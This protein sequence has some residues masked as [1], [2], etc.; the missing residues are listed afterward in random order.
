MPGQPLDEFATHFDRSSLESRQREAEE[1]RQVFLGRFPRESLHQLSLRD[2]VGPDG[3]LD[4][5][6]N[7]TP[8][9]GD[10][11]S[12]RSS[13]EGLLSLK[14]S[15]LDQ[16]EV[17]SWQKAEA[18]W[19]PLRDT[20]ARAQDLAAEGR[21]EEAGRRNNEANTVPVIKRN[22]L[23]HLYFAG[24][25]LPIYRSSAINRLL[26][27][28]S[29]PLREGNWSPLRNRDLLRHLQSLP[30][31]QGW[32]TWEL[33][34]LLNEW[35]RTLQPVADDEVILKIAPGE[36]A[37]RWE[38]C[39][40]GGHACIGWGDI[41]DL[42]KLDTAEALKQAMDACYA[43]TPDSSGKKASRS[44]AAKL[45]WMVRE[46]KEGRRI[47]ANRG[48]DEILAVG[49]VV[50][51]GYLWDDRLGEFGHT[52]RVEWDT[53]FACTMPKNQN[54]WRRTITILTPEQ[55]K[56]IFEGAPES[57]P[58]SNQSTMES[59]NRILHGPPGTGKT[60]RI[61]R[62]AAGIVS[63]GMPH[64]GDAR[65]AY[66]DAV[67]Q[68]RVRLVTFHQ[69][70][71]YEDFIEGIRP[72]M[73]EESASAR[74]QVRDGVFKEAAI[75]AMFACLERSA[76]K[77][78]GFD[79]RW[80]ALLAQ[81]EAAD[82]AL[83]IPGLQEGSEYVVSTTPRGNLDVRLQTGT[84]LLGSR[85]KLE[86][87]Y[88]AC[89]TKPRIN[90]VEAARAD[91]VAGHHNANA[92]VFNF[93]QTLSPVEHV[94]AP[95]NPED[96]KDVV[97]DYLATGEPSGWR[98]RADKNF[99]PY[100][101]II[102]EINRGNISRIFGELITLVEDDKR[103]GGENALQV[104]LPASREVFA[105]PPNLFLLGTMNTADKSLALLDVALRR[106]F[107]FQE[108]PPD[109]SKCG[110]LPEEMRQ[111]LGRLN[112]RIEMRKDRDH[113]IGHAF[114]MN[115]RDAASFDHAFVRKVVP[116]LQEYFFNDIDGARFV[117]GEAGRENDIRGFLRPILPASADARWQ[118]NRW[119]WFS[120]EEPGMPC[121]DRLRTTLGGE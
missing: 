19:T 18:L 54:E 20:L 17:D 49:T 69:S 117:L 72:V 79:A 58:L 35:L 37:E 30:S 60:Y 27:A 6:E 43:P 81:I 99:P 87:I 56:F 63:G 65:T 52:V 80:A 67:K 68:G 5:L 88:A 100:V 25:F 111:V 82:N 109:F 46:L 89:G 11:G 2:Y 24:D 105:V 102:D 115:V 22:K 28:L 62:E 1:Q 121:W 57:R 8:L 59:L 120:D 31:L 85:R 64:G 14:E 107:E 15:G 71:G 93:M 94:T 74:F 101:L 95:L 33:A 21:W 78:A 119:R 75:E 86:R 61:I 98:L 39:L 34:A 66:D 55:K 29:L 84:V 91:G 10:T 53:S 42:R 16:K 104:V 44:R 40:A 13:M 7:R 36:H 114:F 92:A 83:K 32:G 47:V 113:R 38:Q 23:F 112:E 76:G 97:L 45:L 4:W 41:G 51:P 116:L 77:T 103:H 12:R 73:D 26:E 50:S 108:L 106:R 96:R 110:S 90:S 70:F 118:R 3:L 48:M 9:L